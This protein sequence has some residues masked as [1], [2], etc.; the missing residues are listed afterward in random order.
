MVMWMAPRTIPPGTH[1]TRYESGHRTF[2]NLS[3]KC[4]DK[5][6]VNETALGVTRYLTQ[7]LGLG[8]LLRFRR[9]P[10]HGRTRFSDCVL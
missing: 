9:Q 4:S 1:S 10:P 7:V 8:L 5:F 2:Q 6:G 3:E